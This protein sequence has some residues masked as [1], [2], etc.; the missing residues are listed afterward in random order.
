MDCN[1]ERVLLLQ[2]VQR[3]FLNRKW[4]YLSDFMGS[5]CHKHLIAVAFTSVLIV[6]LER[7]KGIAMIYCHSFGALLR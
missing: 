6:W 2:E 3:Y 7:L 4:S 1:T 5:C